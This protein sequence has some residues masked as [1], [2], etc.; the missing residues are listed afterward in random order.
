M[1]SQSSSGGGVDTRDSS[2]K[3]LA[4]AALIFYI[5]ENGREIFKVSGASSGASGAGAGA[6]ASDT[7]PSRT[8]VS[9]GSVTGSPGQVLTTTSVNVN[10]TVSA[11]FPRKAYNIAAYIC[12]RADD[13]KLA[14]SVYRIAREGTMQQDRYYPTYFAIP[15]LCHHISPY[16]SPYVY[17]RCTPIYILQLP[18]RWMT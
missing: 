16:R 4:R 18:R 11:A 1:S 2:I 5:F 7:A 10:P 3:E 9:G 14:M 6:G 13:P 17:H 12:K 15:S 8:T